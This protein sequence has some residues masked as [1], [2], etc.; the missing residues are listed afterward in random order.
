MQAAKEYQVVKEYP[1]GVFSWVDLS[2]TDTAGAKAFYSG[3]FG[4]E[5]EDTPIDMGGFY[6]TFRIGGYSVAGMGELPPDMRAQGVPP[7]WSSYVSHSDTDA[8]AA[9]ITAAGGT[10]MMPPMDV[11]EEGRMLL[12]IDT[13]GAPFGVWQ[14]KQHTGAQLVN[15]P[16]TL[17]WNELQT[18]DLETGKT[19][20]EAV[21]GWTNEADDS[22]YV[23]LR[24]NGRMQAGMLEMNEAFPDDVPPN[25]AVFFLVE[26]L[27]ASSQKAEEL[28]GTILVP[29]TPAGEIGHFS[30]VQD[31]Q[32]AVF[33]MIH[34]NG[35][36]DPPP[37]Y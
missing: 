4:W 31:P 6:T 2:T 15:I 18:R 13:V 8:I 5:A 29:P 10:V 12:A 21:F 26:D 28:G 24:N 34:F 16:N 22:G 3:L 14:P 37:G 27:D 23:M 25:W 7:N 33:T 20:Y 9:K 36:V 1:D 35:P 19:F 30:V 32:G 11:M 17:V